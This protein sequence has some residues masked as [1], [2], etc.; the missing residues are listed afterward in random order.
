MKQFKIEIN[1][2][3][4]CHYEGSKEY[5]LENMDRWSIDYKESKIAECENLTAEIIFQTIKDMI[6]NDAPINNNELFAGN[7]TYL[8]Y[9]RIEDGDGNHLTGNIDYDTYY[10]TYFIWASEVSPDINFTEIQ[11]ITEY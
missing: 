4:V 5:P 9:S 2:K 10:A 1:G 7:E 11:G 8:M 3:E 6:Y